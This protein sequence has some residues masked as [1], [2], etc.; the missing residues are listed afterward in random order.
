MVI[1]GY[2]SELMKNFNYKITGSPKDQIK[3]I[4]EHY[5][6]FNFK[7]K[8]MSLKAKFEKNET[9]KIKIKFQLINPI[10]NCKN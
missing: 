5:K 7:K 9:N 3:A 2:L 1:E 4:Q 6:W 10:S 8:I